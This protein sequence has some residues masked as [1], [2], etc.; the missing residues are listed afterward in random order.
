MLQLLTATGA[1]PRAWSLCERWMQ[2][3]TYAGAVRWIVVDDGAEPQRITL[4]RKDWDVIPVRPAPVW[5]PGD[6]T[7]S[8]NLLAGMTAVDPEHPLVI[9]EDDDYYAPRWLAE[10]SRNLHAA[11]LVGERNSLYYNVQTRQYRRCWNLRHASLCATAMRGTALKTFRA[12]CSTNRKFV[13]IELWRRHTHRAL[14]DG[15]LVVGIK[16][17]P[18]RGGIGAGHRPTFSGTGDPGGAALTRLVGVAAAAAY[19]DLIEA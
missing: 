3:Q 6:N 11:E 1:R 19:S 4:Q 13:D 10:V 15:D 7:Q 14:F 5:R 2:A 17:L 8:R 18:G 12:V 9:I 16:G